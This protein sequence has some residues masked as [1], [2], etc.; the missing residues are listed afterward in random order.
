LSWRTLRS[1]D[2][3]VFARVGRGA[4]RDGVAVIPCWFCRIAVDRLVG[5]LAGFCGTMGD[6]VERVLPGYFPH[7]TMTSE[8]S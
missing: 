8:K 2:G 1:R 7:A 4:G 3:A 5:V 6:M